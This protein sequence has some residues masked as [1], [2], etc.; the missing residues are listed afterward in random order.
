MPGHVSKRHNQIGVAGG[1][2]VFPDYETGHSALIDCLRTTHWNESIDKMLDGYA[3]KKYNPNLA[4]YK[5]FLHQQTG[6]IGNKKI[7][8]FTSGEFEKLW[9]AIECWEGWAKGNVVEVRKISCVY[10]NKK[11]IIYKYCAD[12]M[13]WI[14]KDECINLAKQGKIDAEICT[15]GLG[16]PYVRVRAHSTFQ[17]DFDDLV[18]K[19]HES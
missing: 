5:K 9:K 16:N 7:R 10:K 4:K 17:K 3:P 14:S 1:F 18:A 19:K 11:S 13:G 8:D 6:V 15:S 12:T 2:A